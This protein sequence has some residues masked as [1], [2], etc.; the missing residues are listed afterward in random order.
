MLL[1]QADAARL[2]CLAFLRI[3]FPGDFTFSYTKPEQTDFT[4]KTYAA[5]RTLSCSQ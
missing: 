5:F 4:L 3:P 2:L 1:D